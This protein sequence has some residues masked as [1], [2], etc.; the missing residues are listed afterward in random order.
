MAPD[1]VH[2]P[3]AALDSYRPLLPTW[4]LRDLDRGWRN[5][6]HLAA[7]VGR[8]GLHELCTPL[9]RIL[10]RTPDPDMALNNLERFLATRP[11]A[12]TLPALRKNRGPTR[13]F[14]LQWLGPSHF[15]SDLLSLNP[16]YL[17]MLRV[18]L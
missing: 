4:R 7:A 14:P 8:E 11:G 6:H 1:P 17:D 12:R 9:T 10:P 3:A 18:P 2:D 16:D 5:L 15:F 13:E